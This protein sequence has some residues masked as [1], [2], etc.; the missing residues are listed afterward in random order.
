[1]TAWWQG[2]AAIDVCMLVQVSKLDND[3]AN[4]SSGT[5]RMALPRPAQPPSLFRPRT[6]ASDPYEDTGVS[7]HTATAQDAF[8]DQHKGFQKDSV[9]DAAK[10]AVPRPP[11]ERMVNPEGPRHPADEDQN[12]NPQPAA[13]EESRLSIAPHATTPRHVESHSL[14]PLLIEEQRLQLNQAQN[15]RPSETASLLCASKNIARMEDLQAQQSALHTIHAGPSHDREPTQPAAKNR[16]NAADGEASLGNLDAM[17]GIVQAGLDVVAIGNA[18]RVPGTP[19]QA[20]PPASQLDASVLDAL[21][22]QLRREIERAY[23]DPLPKI[24]YPWRPSQ[25]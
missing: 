14:E 2:V 10:F 21:P 16:S 1:M 4:A 5:N 6:K 20:L 8:A 12:P 13:R 15:T 24:P 25:D 9:A 3:L 17:T 22:L 19:I 18:V 23:G 11:A 7:F